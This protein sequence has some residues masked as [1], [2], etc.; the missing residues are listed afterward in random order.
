VRTSNPTQQDPVYVNT[1][2]SDDR[3]ATY[4]SIS[5]DPGVWNFPI[6]DIG[7][8]NYILKG[9]IREE[10]V[11]FPVDDKSSCFSSFHYIRILSNK[12]N[13]IDLG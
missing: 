3:N 6:E 8:V 1:L 11:T 13:K 12:E 5:Y 10:N 2:K 4:K 9:P 7:R